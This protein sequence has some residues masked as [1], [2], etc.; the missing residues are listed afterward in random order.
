M[1][2]YEDFERP[3]ISVNFQAENTVDRREGMLVQLAEHTKRVN[4]FLFSSA[5]KGTL[6]SVLL[7][8]ISLEMMLM[9]N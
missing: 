1:M 4:A 5:Y 2:Q 8:T 6:W 9:L 7:E 3:D